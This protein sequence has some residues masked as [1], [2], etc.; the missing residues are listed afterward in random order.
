MQ[1]QLDLPRDVS[2]GLK[3]VPRAV[4]LEGLRNLIKKQEARAHIETQSEKT[5]FNNLPPQIA[6]VVSAIEASGGLDVDA[7]PEMHKHSERFREEFSLDK[8][9]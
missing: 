9:N 5:T 8:D 6:Q 2:E 7:V 3:R 1:T 4:L